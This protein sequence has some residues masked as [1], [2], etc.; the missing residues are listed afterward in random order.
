MEA[1]LNNYQDHGLKKKDRQRGGV[2]KGERKIKRVKKNAEESRYHPKSKSIV[3]FLGFHKYRILRPH[4]DMCH[5][6]HT[7]YPKMY[8]FFN[9]KSSNS[10]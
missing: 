5:K 7:K 10:I 9:W 1:N 6:E 4:Y 2:K 8:Q 3:H